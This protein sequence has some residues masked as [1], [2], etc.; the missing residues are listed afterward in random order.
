[1]SQARRKAK[2]AAAA[3][4]DRP[5]SKEVLLNILQKSAEHS[6]AVIQRIRVEVCCRPP[7]STRAAL[8]CAH[9]ETRPALVTQVAKIKEARNLSEE[10]AHLLFQ[11][12]FEHSLDQ[13]IGAV[14]NQYGVSEKAMD[15]SFKQHQNDP[16]VQAAIQGMRVA[17]AE[18]HSSAGRARVTEALPASL[19]RERLKEV[20]TF[21][22]VILERELQPIKEA[23]ARQRQA[24]GQVHAAMPADAMLQGRAPAPLAHHSQPSTRD[25]APTLFACAGASGRAGAGCRSGAHLRSGAGQVRSDR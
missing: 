19:T 11:Q 7:A 1:M 10:Q 9:I 2:K 17:S 21:N 24:G 8:G 23:A 20:M 22:A 4:R 6:K 16:A 14:R 12:N 3:A 25:R 18:V 5:I 13:L 15:S